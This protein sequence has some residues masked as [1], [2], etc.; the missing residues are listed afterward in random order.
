MGESVPAD[1]GLLKGKVNQLTSENETQRLN[2]NQLGTKLAEETQS[3]MTLQAE[4]EDARAQFKEIL[5]ARDFITQNMLRGNAIWNNF[6]K[7][8]VDTLE[9][10]S[11]LYDIPM[12]ILEKE[13]L[14]FTS[15]QEREDFKTI[16][17]DL[18]YAK[19]AKEASERNRLLK[20]DPYAQQIL[21]K[22]GKIEK[23]QGT[24]S[25][26]RRE[27]GAQI[28][29]K[30]LWIVLSTED[31]N[32]LLT[33]PYTFRENG[34][35][36]ALEQP[37]IEA[38]NQSLTSSRLEYIQQGVDGLLRYIIPGMKPTSRSRTR[39]SRTISSTEDA[40]VK[41]CGERQVIG[42]TG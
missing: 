36:H 31:K 20:M 3:R 6:V 38:V 28:G 9:Y 42:I 13:I 16:A 7:L 19:E 1:Y 30:R 33:L 18:E 29:K 32:T 2:L 4:L 23:R 24:I 25:E 11:K 26:L 27:L 34:Q 37:L 8:Y 5:D 35:Y 10:A 40:F 39:L 14:T 17:K 22:A 21:N 41:L 15:L 12:E